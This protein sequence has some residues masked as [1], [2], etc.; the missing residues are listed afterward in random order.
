[1][2]VGAEER[3]EFD[4]FMERLS[5]ALRLRGEPDRPV[6]TDGELDALEMREQIVSGTHPN[7]ARRLA[8]RDTLTLLAEVRASRA[9]IALYHEAI[10]EFVTARAGAT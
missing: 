1:M 9:A 10:Q 4:G 2:T 5:E 6:L 8:A 3:Q 7:Q